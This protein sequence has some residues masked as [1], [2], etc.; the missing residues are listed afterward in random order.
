MHLDLQLETQ[1][2]GTNSAIGHLEDGQLCDF[3]AAPAQHICAT[4][5]AGQSGPA[6]RR[7][8]AGSVKAL[9]PNS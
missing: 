1:R 6:V 9:K 3:P 8:W 5:V 7:P 2:Y 4:I